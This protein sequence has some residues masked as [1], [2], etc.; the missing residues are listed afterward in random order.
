[1]D[2]PLMI[3]ASLRRPGPTDRTD[4]RAPREGEKRRVALQEEGTGVH[5]NAVTEARLASKTR[6]TAQPHGRTARTPAGTDEARE[7][8]PR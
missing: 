2:S 4:E 3:L 6:P 8:F 1:M 7:T 5:T